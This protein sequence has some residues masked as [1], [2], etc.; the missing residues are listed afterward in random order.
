MRLIMANAITWKFIKLE[1]EVKTFQNNNYLFGFY[2]QTSIRKNV[3]IWRLYWVPTTIVDRY[4]AESNWIKVKWCRRTSTCESL[5]SKTNNKILTF[6]EMENVQE[7]GLSMQMDNGRTYTDTMQEYVWGKNDPIWLL[8][9]V[10]SFFRISKKNDFDAKKL[11]CVLNVEAP[12]TRNTLPYVH[13]G[14]RRN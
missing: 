1:V 9:L 10:E 2:L 12:L 14:R 8:L 3:F 5:C 7:N 6:K 11:V 4:H 13:I